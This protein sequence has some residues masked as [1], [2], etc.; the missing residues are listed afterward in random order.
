NTVVDDHD[1][2][3]RVGPQLRIP[4]QGDKLKAIF[5]S[6]YDS[7]SFNNSTTFQE[8]VKGF[9]IKVDE[10][11]STGTGGIVN[12]A[13]TSGNGLYIYYK[14]DI[15]DT[16]RRT[17]YYTMDPSQSMASIHHTFAADIQSQLNSEDLDFETVYV[18]G[19]IGLETKISFPYL[20][21]LKDM[22]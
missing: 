13:P 16:V 5:A 2:T 9:K 7:A 8:K 1:T 17:K 20:A 15:E 22:G 6:S 18:E 19:A 10:T 12:V 4:I 14:N 11:S 3:I 21:K